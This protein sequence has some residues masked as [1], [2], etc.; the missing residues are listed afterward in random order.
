MPTDRSKKVTVSRARTLALPHLGPRRIQLE[1]NGCLGGAITSMAFGDG[2]LYTLR[3][4]KNKI[5]FSG[6]G[7]GFANCKTLQENNKL[8]GQDPRELTCLLSVGCTSKPR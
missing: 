6:E 2:N 7:K 8:K 1:M 5:N 4:L 3:A